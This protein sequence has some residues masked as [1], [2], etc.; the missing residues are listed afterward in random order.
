[1]PVVSKAQARFMGAVASGKLKKKGLS[2][3]EAREYLRGSNVKELPE[4][5]DKNETK[6]KALRNIANKKY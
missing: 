2:K 6:R 1:M 4:K 3:D 5:V